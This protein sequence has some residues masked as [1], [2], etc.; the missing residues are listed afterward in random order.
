MTKDWPTQTT[1]TPKKK[2]R[3]RATVV[4]EQDGMVLLIRERGS[5]RFSLPGGGF[6]GRESTMEA[7][8]RELRE[9]TKLWPVEAKR[10]FDYEGQTQSHRVVWA[11]VRGRVTLQRKEVSEYRWWDGRE[12]VPLLPSAR[13]II[14]KCKGYA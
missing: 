9:E 12:P 5:K 13:A 6:E 14:D 10:M 3:R 7:A 1:A 4:T 8:L 11:Q 2:L